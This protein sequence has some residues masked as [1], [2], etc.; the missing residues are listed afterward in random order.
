[1][2]EKGHRRSESGGRMKK[3]WLRMWA[4]EGAA[5]MRKKGY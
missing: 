2:E 4:V 1:M 5:V 3:K